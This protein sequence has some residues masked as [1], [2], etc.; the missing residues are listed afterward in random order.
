MVNRWESSVRLRLPSAQP[1]DLFSMVGWIL[2]KL[3]G[4]K[5]GYLEVLRTHN[6]DL[7]RAKILAP[8]ANVRIVL[9]PGEIKA[10]SYFVAWRPPLT[11]EPAPAWFREQFRT[12]A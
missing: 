7:A 11:T 2:R 12:A 3:L 1:L 5:L 4:D 9:P 8:I 10:F 6:F